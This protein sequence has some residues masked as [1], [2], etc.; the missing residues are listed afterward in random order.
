MASPSNAKPKTHGLRA[1]PVD[2]DQNLLTTRRLT[3]DL[4]APLTDE[5]QTV[6]AFPDASPTKW[7][8]AHTSWF[9][10]TFVLQPFLSGYRI[11]DPHYNYCF[12][13][14]YEAQGARHPR[15]ARGLLSRPS[16]A[17]VR[18][19]RAHVDAGLAQLFASGQAHE[20]QIAYLLEVGLNHE[21]QHQE[22]LLTDILSLFGSNPLR[23]AYRETPFAVSAQD[24]RPLRWI[25]F[26]GGLYTIGHAEPVFA[27]D[28]ESPP[29]RVFVNPFKLA[30]RLVTNG[31]WQEFMRDGGY[32]THQ[33]WLADGWAKIHEDNWRAP[34]YWEEQ[35][36]VWHQM[37]LYGLAPVDPAAPVSHVSFYEADAYARWTG[38]RLPTEFEWEIAASSVAVEGNMLNSGALRPLPAKTSTD[39]MLS[40]IFGDVWEWTQ[41]AYAPY[42]GYR[43]AEGAIGEYNGKFMCSEQVLRGASCVTPDSHARRT[44]RNFFYPHQRWQFCGLRLADEA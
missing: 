29:H 1:V 7:H 36:G 18:S 17:D 22:L 40:Q 39:M 10:E 42:P 6:Q 13:S 37:T 9:F 41:S 44:Y 27:Y 30:D 32:D 3:L 2:L 12:N 43:P 20:P 4:A 35:D 31:E 14:Y 23:P 34:A 25:S 8:L 5:D 11:F 26:G 38:K 19:Y 21:Q 33:H 15:P 24:T 28:N 16:A